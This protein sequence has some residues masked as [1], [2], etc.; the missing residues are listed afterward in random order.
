MGIDVHIAVLSFLVLRACVETRKE[1]FSKVR[2]RITGQVC[3]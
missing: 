3:G 2:G 1:G